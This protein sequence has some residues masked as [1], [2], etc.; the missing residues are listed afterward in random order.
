MILQG[1]SEKQK[2]LYYEF[3]RG[4]EPV[5]RGGMGVVYRG[6][7]VDEKTGAFRDVAIKE[8][9]PEGDMATRKLVLERARREASIQIRS[10]AI[11]EMLGFV[12]TEERKLGTLKSR[13][14]II[15]EF[16]DGV[17]LDKV[18]GGVY[19]DYRG[20]EIHFAKDLATRY[21]TNREETA[22]Y[23]IKNVLSAIVALH[24]NG[25]LHRD[26]DPSN[27]MI[28]SDG[29]VKLIDFGIAKKQISLTS[30]DGMQSEEGSFVG[31]VE[32]AA[33]ELVSG[34]V[35]Q[36]D[37]TTD[38]YAIGVLFYRLLTG[39]LPFEG[40]RYDIIKGQLNKKPDLGKIQSAKYRA[41]V[42]K[43]MS[44]QQSYRYSSASMM[45]ADLDGPGPTPIWTKYAILGGAVLV[46]LVFTLFVL[47]HKQ[48]LP[49]PPPHPDDTTTVVD[50]TDTLR[51]QE[52]ATIDINEVL[53]KPMS[54]I[55]EILEQTPFHSA[56]LYKASLDS[57]KHFPD[58]KAVVFWD[59]LSSKGELEKYFTIRNPEISSKRVS[60]V[61]SC[62]S[63]EHIDD[64]KWSDNDFKDLI[65]ERVKSLQS[66][67]PNLYILPERLRQ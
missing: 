61:L 63:Y 26:I 1:D 58:E 18:L 43:A 33:P 35:S 10:D 37:F 40:N 24:D 46:I 42:G 45:R 14:Y 34:K 38:I 50:Q 25:Y 54:A 29:K 66:E 7:M 21:A 20:E 62:I 19:T 23:I 9:Q 53:N 16:L 32:Y 51:T 65:T 67:Y 39:R 41:I 17:T 55:W 15:S 49:P 11:V 2:H 31:K 13:Y 30:G 57:E 8:V 27:I 36:Q 47:N 4:Q 28:T 60:Y 22:T 48:I 44:K 56:A 59:N 52:I 64:M 3:D 6:R 12:E 5:G